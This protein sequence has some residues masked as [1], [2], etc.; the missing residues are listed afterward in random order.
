MEGV[1]FRRL[2]VIDR[3]DVVPWSTFDGSPPH[4]PP[5]TRRPGFDQRVLA[6]MMGTLDRF[7]DETPERSADVTAAR[8]FFATWVN[9]LARL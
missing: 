3:G 5:T 8:A 7:D 2:Q 9:W 1:S 6:D 4:A